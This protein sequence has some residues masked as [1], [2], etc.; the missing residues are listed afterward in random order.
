M[1]TSAPRSSTTTS[2]TASPTTASTSTTTSKS[3]S[4]STSIAHTST[5]T[6]GSSTTVRRATAA[7]TRASTATMH[8]STSRESTGI[9][10]IHR[11]AVPARRTIEEKEKSNL[12]HDCI[13]ITFRVFYKNI[14]SLTCGC[15][16]DQKLVNCKLGADRFSVEN[17]SENCRF[18]AKTLVW[19]SYHCINDLKVF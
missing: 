1:S 8:T 13:S 11:P 9:T 6:S 4:T 19:L 10:T 5:S 15:D 17:L 2:T 18:N 7:R 12:Y 3:T 16:W 14:F